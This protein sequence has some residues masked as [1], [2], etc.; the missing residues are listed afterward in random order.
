MNTW[1]SDGFLYGLWANTKWLEALPLFQ[2][3]PRAERVLGHVLFAETV[4][5]DRIEGR[6]LTYPGPDQVP[7]PSLDLF[8]E[9]CDR[10]LAWLPTAD[11]DSRMTF[12]RFDGTRFSTVLSDVVRHVV[13][14]GTY[15]RGHLRGIAET[16]G[17]DDFE[18]TDWVAWAR[19]IG[20]SE[21]V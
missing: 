11:L 21:Q 10:W 1:S 9:S 8:Q 15:H 2:D 20:R 16:E 12:A 17:W 4:W 13:N 3:R 5:L 6:D 14:H 19:A 18:D 7:V